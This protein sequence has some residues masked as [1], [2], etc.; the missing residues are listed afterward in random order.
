MPSIVRKRETFYLAGYDPRGA[1]HY[2]NLYKKEAALQSE[3]NGMKMDISSRKRTDKHVQSWKI[4]SQTG[5]DVTQTNY[6]FLGWDDIIRKRWK[7]TTFT[8]FTDLFYYMK[9]YMFTGLIV[10]FGK[11]SPN[12]M[13]PAFFPVLYLLLTLI[14]AYLFWSF[15]F[16][17]S[18]SIIPAWL[19]AGASLIPV[20]LVIRLMIWIGDKIA[21]FWLL[22]IYVFCAKYVFEDMR[23]L[24]ARVKFFATHIAHVIDHAEENGIDEVLISAHSVGCILAIPVLAQA[25][26]QTNLSKEKLSIVSVMTVG[27]CIPLV[28]FLE[29]S[30]DFKKD[31]KTISTY[32]EIF[33]VDYTAPIDG[34][35][36]PL[37]DYYKHSGL[38]VEGP[39]YRSPRFHTLY[40]K[41]R[42]ETLKKDRYL[43][44]F[45]YLMST[46]I[47]G[48]YDYFKITAGHKH[49]SY[50]KETV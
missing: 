2:Y 11:L 38:E 15:S 22:R 1:R 49:L 16:E 35:C 32:K 10:K 5:E 30:T 44:H 14:L 47:A 24:D 42:Y 23:A 33:W 7:N 20:Y 41:E 39:L 43:T 29:Q 50:L 45:L 40:E 21:V 12:Q 28:S 46:D 48:E 9:T 25:L 3:V 8:I 17:F 31:M 26:E 13:V 37:L 36:F 18:K 19:G 4:E 6:H 34:A 27:E